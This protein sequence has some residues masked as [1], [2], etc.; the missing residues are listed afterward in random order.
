M[1]KKIGSILLNIGIGL[2]SGCVAFLVFVF[3]YG[4][5]IDKIL[6]YSIKTH[7]AVVYIK[8]NMPND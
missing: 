6:D 7:E 8:N 4:S 1:K 2:L 5:R 3:V